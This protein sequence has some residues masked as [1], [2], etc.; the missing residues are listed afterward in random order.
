MRE[1]VRDLDRYPEY[2]LIVD[3][4]RIEGSFFPDYAL[5]FQVLT[6][7]DSASPGAIPSC[8]RSAVPIGWKSAEETFYRYE[9]Y[10]GMVVASK[11]LER[12]AAPGPVKRI[13][14]ATNTSAIPSTGFGGGAGFGNF[15]ASTR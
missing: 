14:P 8:T 3:D 6:L 5:R 1:L 11:S 15:T 4:T 2:S 12:A 9:K 13:R 7:R 10:V